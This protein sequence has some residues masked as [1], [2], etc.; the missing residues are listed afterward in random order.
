MNDGER[1]MRVV[2]GRWEATVELIWDGR[3]VGGV[4]SVTHLGMVR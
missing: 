1:M 3:N 2:M 4:F